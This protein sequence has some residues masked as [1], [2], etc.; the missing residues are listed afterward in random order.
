MSSFL[1]LELYEINAGRVSFNVKA[2]TD[3]LNLEIG[4]AAYFTPLHTHPVQCLKIIVALT[5]KC[6]RTVSQCPYGYIM[7]FF[8]S[9]ILL[10]FILSPYKTSKFKLRLEKKLGEKE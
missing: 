8:L 2:R 9:S 1:L 6:Y 3:F 10:Q 5:I 4:I 7:H